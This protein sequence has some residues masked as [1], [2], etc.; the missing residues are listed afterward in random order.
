MKQTFTPHLLLI[1][2]RK[3][4]NRQQKTVRA[5]IV[6]DCCNSFFSTFQD[7]CFH[8][9]IESVTTHTRPAWYQ[10]NQHEIVNRRGVHQATWL[11]QRLWWSKTIGERRM[12]FLQRRGPSQDS[13]APLHDS[14]STNRQAAQLVIDI[15]S[16]IFFLKRT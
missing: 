12:N 9:V 15:E 10:A 1:L 16:V 4:W 6:V 3:Q 8:G 7:V 14:T 13:H 11:A 2:F 5:S